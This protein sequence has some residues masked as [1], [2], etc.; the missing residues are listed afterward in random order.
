METKLKIYV[1]KHLIQKVTLNYRKAVN[2]LFPCSVIKGSYITVVC[3]TKCNITYLV[4]K[5]GLHCA[6]YSTFTQRFT[7][8]KYFD[9]CFM[10]KNL[11][12]I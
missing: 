1:R 12:H 8:W 4:I 7:C 11:L 10:N 5:P 2:I 3:V 9:K 6:M